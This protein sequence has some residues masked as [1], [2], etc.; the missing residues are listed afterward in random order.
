[1]PEI[2]AGSVFLNAG[3]LD[4]NSPFGGDKQSSNGR[5]FGKFGLEAF[6]EKKSVIGELA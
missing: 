6:M 4:F 1:M 5:E 2:R 3:R